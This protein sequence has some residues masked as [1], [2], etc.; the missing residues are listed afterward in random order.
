M[1]GIQ[2]LPA[3][4]ATLNGTSAVLLAAGY[5]F[6]RR[7]QRRAHIRC[8]IAAVITSALFLT[9]YVIYHAHI[10]SRPY[11]GQGG[12]RPIYYTILATHVV[13]AVVIVPLVIMTL[14]RA[15]RGRFALHQEDRPLTLP[16]WFY[17][18][19]TGVIVYVMLYH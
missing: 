3:V 12:L 8:M 5:T 11:P 19:I 9:S 17:V 13:L 14:A 16:L 2:D 1:I 15:V 18:S 6:I 7:G 4:N 10:G